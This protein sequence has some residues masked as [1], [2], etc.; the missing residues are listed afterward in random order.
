MEARAFDLEREVNELLVVMFGEA[1]RR[2]RQDLSH[3]AAAAGGLDFDAFQ[4]LMGRCERSLVAC[5]ELLG[6]IETRRLPHRRPR[7]LE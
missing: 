2:H 5:V 4:K 1:V 3:L 6:E 7:F